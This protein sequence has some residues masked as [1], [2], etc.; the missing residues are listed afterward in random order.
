MS[1][2]PKGSKPSEGLFPCMR[3][4]GIAMW[5]R[6]RSSRSQATSTE[7]GSRAISRER[8][9]AGREPGVG[10]CGGRVFHCGLPES[11]GMFGSRCCK[12]GDKSRVASEEH[13][14][15]SIALSK[16]SEHELH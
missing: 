7:A 4:R 3:D 11:Y 15:V 2:L 14:S 16:W 6:R 10:E 12:L 13:L 8:S 9:K 5:M 1:P